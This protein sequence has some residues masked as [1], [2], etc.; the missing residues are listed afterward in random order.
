MEQHKII[1][2]TEVTVISRLYRK[3]DR[4]SI[5]DRLKLVHRENGK[6]IS[7]EGL[8]IFEYSRGKTVNTYNIKSDNAA[9]FKF[10][11]SKDKDYYRYFLVQQPKTNDFNLIQAY[12]NQYYGENKIKYKLFPVFV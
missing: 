6:A 12:G 10:P 7:N 4:K 8:R 11:V 9:N 1:S 2:T 3:D 5:E